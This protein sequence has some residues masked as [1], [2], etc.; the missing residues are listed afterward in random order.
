MARV[1]FA[2]GL[3]GEIGAG[4][5]ESAQFLQHHTSALCIPCVTYDSSKYLAE[6]LHDQILENKHFL[7][8]PVIDSIRSE[9]QFEKCR[10]LYKDF[11]LLYLDVPAD[12]RFQRRNEQLVQAGKSPLTR[13]EFD[14]SHKALSDNG[15]SKLKKYTCKDGLIN[16]TMSLQH[17]KTRLLE[18]INTPHL[19]Y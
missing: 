9:A 8:V 19:R 17:L 15:V 18:I 2:I 11:R 3:A 4:K 6:A 14:D 7:I 12:L 13:E 10:S 16:N 1:H 5:S